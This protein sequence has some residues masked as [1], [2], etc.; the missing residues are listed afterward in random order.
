MTDEPKQ[1][2]FCTAWDDLSP[3]HAFD[4]ICAGYCQELDKIT[5]S[6]EPACEH[7]EEEKEE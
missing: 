1:C 4:G 3:M 2:Q 7:Y 5:D 6:D